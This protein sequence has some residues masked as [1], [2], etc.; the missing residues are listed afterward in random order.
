MKV[1]ETREEM[2]RVIRAVEIGGK[3]YEEYVSELCDRLMEAGAFVPPVK[4]GETVFAA[5]PALTKLDED[6]IDEY[7]VRGCGV[8]DEGEIFILDACWEINIVEDMYANLTREDA[9][10]WL[11]KEKREE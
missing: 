7:K 9:E 2:L 8:T 5:C 3:T 10:V 6:I 11:K 4:C 1:T